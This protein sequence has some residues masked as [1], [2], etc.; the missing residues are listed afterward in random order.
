MD[1]LGWTWDM[2]RIL[3]KVDGL[4]DEMLESGKWREY[5]CREPETPTMYL[6]I[7]KYMSDIM[8]F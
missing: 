5:N 6:R 3:S 1:Q 8:S 4:L 2:N 7:I